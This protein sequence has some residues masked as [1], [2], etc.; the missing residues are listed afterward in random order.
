M[1]GI[2]REQLEALM[3]Y[4]LKEADRQASTGSWEAAVA[5]QLHDAEPWPPTP[6]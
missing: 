4:I 2:I 6:T 5:L 3:A 1:D